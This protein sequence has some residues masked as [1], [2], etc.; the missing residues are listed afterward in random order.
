MS[1]RRLSQMLKR[2]RKAKGLNKVELAERAQVTTA[3]CFGSGHTRRHCPVLK[4]VEARTALRVETNRKE[5]R[6]ALAE[7]VPLFEDHVAAIEVRLP[8]LRPE[9]LLEVRQLLE[10]RI[11]T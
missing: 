10:A 3:S 4:A 1:P 2:L 7:A 6:R 8:L 11:R 9:E 5:T